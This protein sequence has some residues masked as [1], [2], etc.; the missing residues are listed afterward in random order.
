MKDLM[1]EGALG[2]HSLLRLD[3][4]SS[5]HNVLPPGRSRS[6][7]CSSWNTGSGS[8]SLWGAIW[9]TAVFVEAARKARWT[10]MD[11]RDNVSLV[12]GCRDSI[13]CSPET[14]YQ[15]RIFLHF[16]RSQPTLPRHMGERLAFP[17]SLLCR[18]SSG[19]KVNVP[20]G[21]GVMVTSTI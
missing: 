6:A 5:R 15:R 19:G 11:L 9:A 16:L 12:S 4:L 1:F 7:V 13:S 18:N 17:R 14:H 8:G 3:S 20:C 2:K 10:L 21:P